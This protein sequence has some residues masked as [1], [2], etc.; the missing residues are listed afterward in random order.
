[1]ALSQTRRKG[2]LSRFR[3]SGVCIFDQD[4]DQAIMR[5]PQLLS[6]MLEEGD[7]VSQRLLDRIL[8]PIV[9]PRQLE[10]AEAAGFARELIRANQMILAS[11]IQKLLASMMAGNAAETELECS[12]RTLLLE[13]GSLL[14]GHL[15]CSWDS[16]EVSHRC[17]LSLHLRESLDV[18]RVVLSGSARLVLRDL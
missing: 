5:A 3:S 15:G 16:P 9:P 13:V 14:R 4:N 18:G 17:S 7:E 2:L 8:S 1:M 12:Y 6:S 10:N 11:H